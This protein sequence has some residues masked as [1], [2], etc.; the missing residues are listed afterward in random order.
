MFSLHTHLQVLSYTAGERRLTDRR[1]ANFTV[2]S[3]FSDPKN[4][5]SRRFRST[6]QMRDTNS[7]YGG[8]ALSRRLSQLGLGLCSTQR[9][10]VRCV[11]GKWRRSRRTQLKLYTHTSSALK[12][13]STAPT[14]RKPLHCLSATQPFPRENGDITCTFMLK[15]PLH[16]TL[17]LHAHKY[18][19]AGAYMHMLDVRKAACRRQLE[20]EGV[21]ESVNQMQKNQKVRLVPF[22]LVRRRSPKRGRPLLARDRAVSRHT[23]KDVVS[24]RKNRRVGSTFPYSRSDARSPRSVDSTR[25]TE[26]EAGSASSV[27]GAARSNRAPRRAPPQSANETIDTCPYGRPK[28]HFPGT[29]LTHCEPG[30]Y[31]SNRSHSHTISSKRLPLEERSIQRNSAGGVHR[32]HESD[33]ASGNNSAE[34]PKRD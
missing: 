3:L 26:R 27:C 34:A 9:D 19:C 5:V 12:Y 29:K 10:R 28:I 11:G 17:T 22:A 18:V 16:H 30:T 15:E 24:S 8:D 2:W 1:H 33:V 23:G 7:R 25:T 4:R 20:S 21:I 6:N 31:T 32:V 14:P 13:L